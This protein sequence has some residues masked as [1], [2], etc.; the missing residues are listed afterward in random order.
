MF[1]NMK[2]LMV[3]VDDE[4]NQKIELVKAYYGLRNKK[5]AIVKMLTE[6]K[7]EKLE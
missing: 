3:E 1:S 7:L 4:L 5:D 6:V 2:K